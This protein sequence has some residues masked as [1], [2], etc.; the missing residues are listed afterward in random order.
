MREVKLNDREKKALRLVIQMAEKGTGGQFTWSDEVVLE[1]YKVEMTKAQMS[2]YLAMLQ[3]KGLITIYP[4][5]KNSDSPGGQIGVGRLGDMEN[6][7][8][9]KKYLFTTHRSGDITWV[10]SYEGEKEIARLDARQGN[11]NVL[12]ENF[13]QMNIGR[14]GWNEV[15]L[16]EKIE[17]LRESYADEKK[18]T[19]MKLSNMVLINC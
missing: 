17:E 6:L 5:D 18:Y 9:V 4:K 12:V 13:M 19:D 16:K 10:N 14:E 8:S 2:G 3:R 11:I 7:D 15:A 1:S